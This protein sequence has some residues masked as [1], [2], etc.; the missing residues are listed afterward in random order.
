MI[1][2][3]IGRR[4]WYWPSDDEL[5]EVGGIEIGDKDQACDAGVVYVHSSTRVNLIVT[6][7]AGNIRPRIYVR[8]LQEGDERPT[9]GD[10][11]FAEWMP[12]QVKAADKA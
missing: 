7:H 2:P 5:N 10:E 8:L 4:V 9:V 3:T 11:P 12:Y 6:D 1:H